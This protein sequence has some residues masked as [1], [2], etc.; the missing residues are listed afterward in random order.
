MISSS[1]GLAKGREFCQMLAY[2]QVLIAMGEL[3]AQNWPSIAFES[4]EDE[5]GEREK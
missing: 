4:K 5:K 1:P 3:T 2:E